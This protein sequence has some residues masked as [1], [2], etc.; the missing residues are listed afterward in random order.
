MIDGNATTLAQQL[1]DALASRGACGGDREF[2]WA[3]WWDR[4]DDQ[5]TDLIA[6]LGIVMRDGSRIEYRR[7]SKTWQVLGPA[8]RTR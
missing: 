6:P 7:D 3:A 8:E 1:V 5:A 2:V 4:I